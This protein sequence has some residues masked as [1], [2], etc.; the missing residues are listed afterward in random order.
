MLNTGRPNF[1]GESQLWGY[2]KLE[3]LGNDSSPGAHFGLKIA[4][5]LEN[6]VE[7][8]NIL[9]RLFICVYFLKNGYLKAKKRKIGH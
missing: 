7:S 4:P 8:R 2:F 1:L 6:D 3:I 9:G 5:E